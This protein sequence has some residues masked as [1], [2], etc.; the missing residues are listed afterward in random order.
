MSLSS[1]MPQWGD[2]I[3]PQWYDLWGVS[4]HNLL[5]TI[6]GL[7]TKC[8]EEGVKKNPFVSFFGDT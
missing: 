3:M 5:P 8:R 2:T 4:A 1:A 6:C 7:W